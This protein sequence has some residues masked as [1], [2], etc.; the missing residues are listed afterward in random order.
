MAT[1]YRPFILTEDGFPQGGFIAMLTLLTTWVSERIIT[2]TAV[3]VVTVVAVPTTLVIVSHDHDKKDSIAVIQPADEHSKT[4]LISTVK[5]AGDD[6]IAKLNTAESGCT[7]QVTQTVSTS[8][9][10]ATVQPA[11]AKAKTQ[12]HGSV[13]PLVAAVKT[14]Q[15]RFAK[16][17][18]VTPQDEE[19]ELEHL[20]LLEVIALGDGHSTGTITVSCQTVMITIQETIQI[21]VIQQTPAPCATKEERDD[22]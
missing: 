8:K 3:T 17:I 4:I 18:F 6:L 12:I 5:K 7:T 1:S 11:L 13:A 15:D 22:D 21:T 9:V 20:K 2:L 10:S 14:D 19:N 16:L